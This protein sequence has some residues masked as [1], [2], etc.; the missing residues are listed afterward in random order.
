MSAPLSITSED[1]IAL[2]ELIDEQRATIREFAETTGSH[3]SWG[4]VRSLESA[5]YYVWGAVGYL[6]QSEGRLG[7]D[8][9]EEGH[10][11]MPEEAVVS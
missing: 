7:P 1:M 2:H 4:A 3:G 8:K 6:A 11:Q 10:V 9:A 5:M